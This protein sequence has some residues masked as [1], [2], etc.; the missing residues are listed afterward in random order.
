M[1]LRC[2][3]AFAAVNNSRK[4]AIIPVYLKKHNELF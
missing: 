1:R 3:V 2:L 4:G